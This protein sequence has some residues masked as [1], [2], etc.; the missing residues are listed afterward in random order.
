VEFRGDSY[1]SVKYTKEDYHE[2]EISPSSKNPVKWDNAIDIF[3]DRIEG[4]YLNVINS[5]LSND[6][7]LLRDGFVVMAIN[8]LLIETL[9]Q[10]KYGE[11]ETIGSN[12]VR[13]T[14]FL[15]EEFPTV[16]TNKNSAKKFYKDIRCG[17]LHSAQTKGKSKLTF[18]KNYV[19]EISEINSV[20][21]I[22]VDVGNFTN[23]LRE[24]YENYVRNLRR[25]EGNLRGNFIQKMNF[26]CNK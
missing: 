3:E 23:V 13:Y 15:Y 18:G 19:I 1:I 26:I 20:E 7:K 17:I 12:S 4:R 10:F 14:Q 21:Y 16:F 22:S 25:D 24:Y 9:M 11:D 2:I 6:D 5:F 8:C